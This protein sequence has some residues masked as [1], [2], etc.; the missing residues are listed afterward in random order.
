MQVLYWCSKY[1]SSSS[2]SMSSLPFVGIF[3]H[4]R[5]CLLS[6]KYPDFSWSLKKANRIYQQTKTS[7]DVQKDVKS[8]ILAQSI[9]DGALLWLLWDWISHNDGGRFCYCLVFANH[10]QSIHLSVI[11]AAYPNQV[12]GALEPS[13]V[14]RR[15]TDG[16]TLWRG[17]QSIARKIPRQ[18]QV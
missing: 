2:S 15:L 1:A 4:V 5:D 11:Q 9:W 16:E 14:L 8:E 7:F 12:H 18:T 6:L 10:R 17:W 13:L 3:K